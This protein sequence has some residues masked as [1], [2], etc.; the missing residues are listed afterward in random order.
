MTLKDSEKEDISKTFF[1]CNQLVEF[2]DKIC[3][4]RGMQRKDLKAKFYIDH[5]V[6][7]EKCCLHLSSDIPEFLPGTSFNTPFPLPSTDQ[8]AGAKE[9]KGGGLGSRGWRG[10]MGLTWGSGPSCSWGSSG[11]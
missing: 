6:D 4:E 3:E 10:K 11:R 9:K 7:W 5:G 8:G 1:F 2:L